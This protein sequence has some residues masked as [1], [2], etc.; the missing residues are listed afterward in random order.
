MKSPFYDRLP[1]SIL[2]SSR[3]APPYIANFD[4]ASAMLQATGACLRR[5]DF[6]G[7]GVPPPLE[8]LAMLLDRLPRS[9]RELIYTQG[10]AGEGI[11]P[12][13]LGDVSAEVVAQWMVSEYPQQMYPAVAI[14]SS[15][16]A[17]VHLCAA[18]GMPWLPQTYLIPVQHQGQIDPDDPKGALEWGLRH[19]QPLLEANQDLQLHHMHDPSQDRLTIRGMTYFRVKRL[20]LGSLY[21]GFL[22]NALPPGGTIFLVECQ[23]TWPTTQIGD[24]HI[25]QFGA[26][27]GANL[28]D[29]FE[30]NEQVAE[31]LKRYGSQRRRWEPPDPDGE[32]PEAE[33]GFEATLRKDVERFARER[34]Y[35][36][37]RIVFKEPEH[38]SPFVAELYRWWYQQRQIPTNRLLVESFMLLE[39]LWALRTGSVPFWMKFNMKP[40]LSELQRYLDSTDP[41]DEIYMMLFSHGVD[42][43]GLASIEDWRTILNRARVRGEFVGVQEDKYPADLATL[44][45]YHTEIKRII[46]A[47]Y[48]LPQSLTLQQLDDFIQTAGDRFLVRWD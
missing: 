22:E 36:L 48:P 8:P 30:G 26:L 23:R 2:A 5:E 4:S 33:W 24:R 46:E 3:I 31:Y 34:G 47:R 10:S 7:V 1:N 39:P 18:F 38:L 44:V 27:G 15:S 20:R 16:G 37:R 21:E 45:R 11:P 43:I 25:F 40:S 32:R 28:N 17:L 12:E 41:Y 14:G 9:I 6:P 13:R 19:A 42:S 29:F 35:R